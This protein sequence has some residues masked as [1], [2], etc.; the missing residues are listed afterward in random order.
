MWCRCR[1]CN[2]ASSR[3]SSLRVMIVDLVSVKVGSSDVEVEQVATTGELQ[4][5]CFR[6]RASPHLQDVGDV[7]GAEGREGEPVGERTGHGIGAVDLGQ[8]QNLAHMVAGVEAALLQTLV[9][10]C[11]FW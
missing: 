7:L 11:S 10:G 3:I 6:Q 8:G 2:C 4:R 1:R 9:V 5:S